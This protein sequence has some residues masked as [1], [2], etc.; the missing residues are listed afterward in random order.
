MNIS[1][2]DKVRVVQKDEILF[3]EGQV[4][5]SLFIVKSGEI[6]GLKRSKERLIPVLWA[7]TQRVLGEE[8]VLT[9][10]EYTYS[11][12]ALVESE[13]I[14][15]PA[16]QVKRLMASAPAWMSGLLA[17]LGERSIGMSSA[18]AEHRISHPELSGTQELAAQEENRLKKLLN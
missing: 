15:V 10:G 7:N 13:V 5:T 16:D 17:T 3:K 12:I 6:V 8:A 18:I 1:L 4:T 11:A 9:G 14:E 2:N